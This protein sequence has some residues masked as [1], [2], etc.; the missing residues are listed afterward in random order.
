MSH[1]CASDGHSCREYLQVSRR[2]FM[3]AAGVVA[4]AA[5]APAW[6]P[7]VAFAQGGTGATRDV[8][9]QVY[10]RGGCDG[11]SVVAP[12]GDNAYYAL[13]PTLALA[14]PDDA[15]AAADRKCL[16]LGQHSG[17]AFGLHQSL[18]ALMP[19]YQDGQML[20]VHAT[21]LD[22]DTR[23]HFDA[24]R[25]MEQGVNPDPLAGTGWLG[26]H[27]Q[28]V[29]P[30]TP[31]SS[32]RALAVSDTIQQTLA[33][34]P[35][36][37]AASDPANVGFA[38]S[39][40][41]ASARLATLNSLYASVN[42]ATK[43]PALSMLAT[44]NQ[45]DAIDFESYQ[46]AGAAQYPENDWFAYGLKATAALIKAQVGVEA[47]ALDVGGYDTHADQGN[48]G[49]EYFYSILRSLGDSLAAFMADLNASNVNFTI[50]VMSEFGRTAAENGSRGTDHGHGNI[51]LA[52]GPGIAGGRVLTQ[53]PGLSPGNLDSSGD[54]RNTIDYRDVLAEIVQQRLGNAN[55]ASVFPGY[56]PTF[57]GVTV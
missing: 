3:Q 9:I 36:A 50:V 11:L 27:L 52:L 8:I 26:R 42:D 19:A 48:F 39:W 12:Y 33:G 37:V 31:G 38:G 15:G 1:A 20:I 17:V 51:M 13:R 28:S 56:V 23:S 44:L 47:V 45:L 4:A 35:S 30:L 41:S 14:R 21:G 53:W 24:Q 57:R 25:W 6:L 49:G 10:L 2:R 43:N 40:D 32:L 16:D 34:A 55:L 18:G 22:N 29:A 54:L 7:R 46:P 5:A